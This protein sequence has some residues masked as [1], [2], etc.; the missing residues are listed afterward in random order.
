[1]NCNK[2]LQKYS[3]RR[4]LAL[5]AMI[6]AV[7]ENAL[8]QEALRIATAADQAETSAQ[9]QTE[10]AS[11]GHYNFLL[12]PTAWRFTSGL[13]LAY[14]D[15]I[16]STSTPESDFILTPNL[17]SV[18]H[19]PV[20]L[21]NSLDIS[22][23]AGYSY[24]F[25][26][27]QYN[28]FY[29]NS[30]S[31]LSFDV[32]VG[33]CKIN[34]HDQISISQYTYEN[35][36]VNVG[37]ANTEFLQNSAGVSATYNLENLVPS[38]GYDHVDYV[39]L[40]NDSTSPQTT[41]ENFTGSLGCPLRD[42][43]LV[44]GE[45]GGSLVDF[46]YNGS[47]AAYYDTTGASQW[48]VGAYGTSQISDFLSANLHV[49]YTEYYSDS[50]PTSESSGS[51][52]GLY[53]SG[54]LTHQVNQ[55]LNYTLTAGRSTDLSSAGQPQTRTYIQLNPSYALLH[56][57]TITTPFS[58][59][60]GTRLG[61]A[62]SGSSDYDQF[63]IGIQVSRVITKKLSASLGYQYVEEDSQNAGLSYTVDIIS[64]NLTYQF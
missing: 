20:T 16:R 60:T 4:F 32:F 13:G 35:P 22:L 52:P 5:A 8:G 21:N 42:E 6:I 12:G 38:I 34:L 14:N 54:S 30:G 47:D 56:N 62:G 10:G 43:L 11:E 45:A 25:Q 63:T 49:G 51:H 24:Y 23:G 50:T 7:R 55:W 48:Y 40:N 2:F 26:H 29:I 33:D 3:N 64:L 44:G 46:S 1:M 59:Q 31:G 37:N 39:P 15:N 18:M 41:S 27:S 9:Q 58:Y 19:W 57:Y 28:Q 53:F 17:T 61:Y 36:G